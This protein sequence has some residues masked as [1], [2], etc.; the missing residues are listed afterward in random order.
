MLTSIH[1]FLVKEIMYAFVWTAVNSFLNSAFPEFHI[2]CN[3]LVLQ[4]LLVQT[5]VFFRN[6]THLTGKGVW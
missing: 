3:A 5:I 1:I 6:I 2:S 4:T